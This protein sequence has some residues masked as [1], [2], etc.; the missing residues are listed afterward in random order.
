MPSAYTHNIIAEEAFDG[1]SG[2]SPA[3]KHMFLFGAQGGDPMF[4]YRYVAMRGA[5]PGKL[6]HRL[7]IYEGLDAMRV[8]VRDR[9]E[10]MPYALGYVSHYAADTVF[11][12]FVYCLSDRAGGSHMDRN[13]THTR[14]ERELD[15]YFVLTRRGVRMH[16]YSLPYAETDVRIRDVAGT[17]GSALGALGL[18]I[19]PS[20]VKRAVRGYFRFLRNTYD[21]RG[22]RRRISDAVGRIGIKPFGLL[23]ALFAR[24]TFSSAAVNAF[25]KPWYNVADRSVVRTDSADD[26]FFRAVERTVQYACI[27][28]MCCENGSALPPELFSDNLLTGIPEKYGDIDRA[29]GEEIDWRARLRGFSSE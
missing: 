15:A 3:D 5:G 8:Y 12:P 16:E 6:L 26:L 9:R 4:F 22:V 20:D 27:F 1:I 17:L 21:K 24:D 11:H 19:V 18:V 2:I 23:G 14:I 28:R 10:A 7:G 25:R 13:I 29:Y